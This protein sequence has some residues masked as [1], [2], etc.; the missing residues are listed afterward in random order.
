MTAPRAVGVRLPYADVP[1][2]VRDWVERELGSPVVAAAEQVG[3][4]SPGCATRLTCADGTRAFVK[5]VGAGLN[6]DTPRLFRREVGV[7]GHLGEHELWAGLRASYDDGDWVALLIE[8]V[9]GR[10][11]DFADAGEM[12]AVLVGA[13]RLSAVLQQR[14]VPASL[15]L[16]DVALVLRK[17]ADCLA[18]LADAPAAAPVPDW[19]RGDPHGWAEVLRDHAA[20]PMSHLAHWDIRVDNLL[21]RPDGEVVFLDWGLAARGPAWVDALLARMERVDEPWFDDSAGSSPALAAAGDDAVTAFL[22]GFAAHMAVR[23]VVAVDVN[24]PTL[25]DFR[26]R[27]SRRMLEAV[28]RRTGR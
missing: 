3:G 7:L 25:N 28:A 15:D 9:E 27:E 18:T 22:A 17:W 16:V 10:H 8:D 19:L 1:A 24:L 11:P 21:R 26:I 20:R 5:A 4:M 2:G 23:S 13:D 14:T 6:P 12:E